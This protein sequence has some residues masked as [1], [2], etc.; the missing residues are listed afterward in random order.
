M[1][2]H[3]LVTCTRAYSVAQLRHSWVVDLTLHKNKDFLLILLVI[4]CTE[5]FPVSKRMGKVGL[6]RALQLVLSGSVSKG[7]LCP[8]RTEKPIC[9]VTFGVIWCF[10]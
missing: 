4:I 6:L 7:Q 10:G 2:S 9:F 1:M 5:T 3:E 8:P